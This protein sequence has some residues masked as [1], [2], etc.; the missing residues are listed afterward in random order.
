MNERVCKDCQEPFV[1]AEG[2]INFYASRSLAVPLRCLECRK[3][4]R[5]ERQLDHDER[6]CFGTVTK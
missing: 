1:L 2:E 4:R 3:R 5:A 6:G